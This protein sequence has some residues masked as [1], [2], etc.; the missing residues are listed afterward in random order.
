LRPTTGTLRADG[1]SA[2]DDTTFEP[3]T[4]SSRSIGC[5]SG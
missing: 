5:Y 1:L 4:I 2:P 3:I